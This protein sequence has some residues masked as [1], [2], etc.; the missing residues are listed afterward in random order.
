[1]KVPAQMLI[2][3]S[4]TT[5]FLGVT[6]ALA[7]A[8][9]ISSGQIASN[10]P[11]VDSQASPGDIL[12][13]V[14]D[15]LIRSKTGYDTNM[16][17]VIVSNPAVVLNKAT[18]DT[19]PVQSYGE[20]LL[21]VSSSNGEIKR[22]DFITSSNE[23]GVGQ[24]AIESGFVIGKALEDLEEDTGQISVF[25][26]IQFK[27][28]ESRFSPG[29]LLDILTTSLRNPENLPDLLRYLFA[30][31]IG[32][33]AFL[34]GFFFFARSLRS[35]VDAIGRNPLAKTS[36]QVAMLLNLVGIFILTAAGVALSLFIILYL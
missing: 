1:M 9:E 20:V 5:L 36:I 15:G 7:A 12:T 16:F 10:L 13:R 17:G 18:I 21:N 33:G 6:P 29:R 28:I 32:V 27:P 34:F 8:Q 25:V 23:P 31:L 24:K 22:G 11:V 3:L 2:N 30:I 19:Q 35:G 26:N 14:E 4:L